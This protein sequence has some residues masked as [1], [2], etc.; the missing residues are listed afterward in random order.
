MVTNESSII[1]NGVTKFF[2]LKKFNSRTNRFE[3]QF[4]RA[5][6]NASL[7]IT[8]G[9]VVGIIG[10]NGSG[11]T[12]MLRIMAGIMKPDEGYIEVNG[13]VGPLLQLGVGS[14]DENT[15]EENIILN[16]LLLGFTK[17]WITT[18]LSQ[19]LEFSEL[20]DYRKAKMRALSTGMKSRIMF[21]TALLVDPD[22]LLVDEVVSVG[23][24][25]FRQKSFKAFS[26]FKNKG[27]TVVIVSHSMQQIRNLCDYV[28]L[29]DKG[30]I[31]K[32]GNANEV[33]KYYEESI[34]K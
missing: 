13:T 20:A 33:S 25:A 10:K 12:T 14:N 30:K 31:I 11:K 24:A 5:I 15:V 18:K 17:K 22:V 9:K 6:D 21:S 16:G 29:L 1:V 23:D 3:F 32:S 4:I 28:Y 7:H 26:E 27:K 19:I 2:K 8:E 34:S